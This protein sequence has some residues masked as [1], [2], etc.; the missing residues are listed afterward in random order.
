M[1]RYISH[2]E[3][4]KLSSRH[5]DRYILREAYEFP[6]GFKERGPVILFGKSPEEIFGELEQIAREAKEYPIVVDP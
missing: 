3:I 2:Y 1:A 4:A 6:S 5:A